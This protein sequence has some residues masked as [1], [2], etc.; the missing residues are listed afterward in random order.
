MTMISARVERLPF[1]GFHR[2]MLLA[3]G[4]G[5]T[6]DAMDGAVLAFVI[7]VLRTTWNLSTA[8]L[9]MM[10]SAAFVGAIV[11]AFSAGTLGDLIGRRKVMMSAL[12]LY[13]LASAASA[14]VNDWHA[15]VALR[16]V[17]GIGA[18]AESVI[19]APYLSEFVARRYRGIFT[20]ALAGF[21]SFGFVL[22]ALLG[23]FI[24]PTS[25]DGWRYVILITA[26]PVVILL[27][28]R[29]TL[30]ESPRWLESQGRAAEAEATLTVME[31]SA[32]QR[33]AALPAL[34]PEE[35]A[36]QTPSAERGSPLKN[37]ATLLSR[38]LRR[39]TLMTWALWM[40]QA[41]SYY[42]FFTWIP[43]LLVQNGMSL[44]RSFGFSIVMYVA[45]IPGYFSA[46]W[47]NEVI[48]R[49]AVI[50]SYMLLGG[51]SA[52]TMGLATGETQI[53]FA[54]MALSFFMNGAYAGIYA[55]TPEVFPTQVRATGT[56][57]AS[58]MS[59][60]GGAIAPLMVG[61]VYPAAGFAGVFSMTT[62]VLL[63]GGLAVLIFGVS[64]KNRSLE[65]ISAQEM[66]H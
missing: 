58:G 8:E 24:V 60:F 9:G 23:Y 34:D 35:V 31:A 15:F 25:P 36:S 62:A 14:M 46:A 22:A 10:V 42:A 5:Y 26:A 39:I 66:A 13:C 16:I 43:S 49:K 29:R 44:T 59:R 18:G 47:L 19:I 50:V 37:Y 48:G 61:L 21:F 57:M 3:G 20:G 12:V 56:G 32:M 40:S 38:K 2:K 33:G 11:G 4:L 64:T 52:I 17:A 63:F 30:P 27:W 7:P 6:F 54:G 51:V 53:M 1:S 28:W 65:A 41:F 45:Q 55:Y